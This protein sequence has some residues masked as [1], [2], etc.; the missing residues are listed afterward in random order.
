[1]PYTIND[2]GHFEGL[3]PT[4]GRDFLFS[5]QHERSALYGMGGEDSLY[6]FA[7]RDKLFGGTG[8]DWLYGGDGRDV[9]WG[10][11]GRDTFDYAHE[12]EGRDKIKDFV[13]GEDAINIAV[14]AYGEFERG[15][16]GFAFNPET[17]RLTYQDDDGQ[18]FIAK[19]NTAI[20]DIDRDIILT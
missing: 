8:N 18:V 5:G 6:G 20:F 9:L 17:R 16:E 2:D 7:G 10:G 3:F 15:L 11:P 12:A 4:Q 13:P 1:M 19:L 14:S